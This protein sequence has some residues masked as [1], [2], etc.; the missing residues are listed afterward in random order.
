MPVHPFLNAFTTGEITDQLIART[1]WDKYQNAAA[2]LK[3]FVV[4]PYG[5][6]AR[7]AGTF[8]AGLAKDPS[9]RVR[10]RKFE[11]SITQAY[12]VEFG[13]LYARFWANRAP[14]LEAG[15]PVEVVTP[16]TVD[17]LRELRFEQ[18]ADVLY[19]THRN[20]PPAKLQRT[21][22][23]SFQLD[24][25][26][27][28]P[29]PTFEQE[30]FPA[31]T[32]TLS[33]TSGHIVT[34]TAS[35]SVFL[36]GDVGR[37]IR[38][39]VGRGIITA[40]GG[41]TTVTLDIL[42]AFDS[43]G[44]IAAGDWRMDGS[45]NAGTLTTTG[46]TPVNASV[47]LTSSLAAFRIPADENAYVY[48]NNGIVRITE[49]V[50]DT[51]VHGVI[52]KA[53]ADPTDL[54]ADAGAWTL[55]RQAWSVQNGFP[56]VVALFAQRLWFAGSNNFPDRVWGSVVADYENFG[57]GVADDDAVEY[58]LAMSGV[59]LI[60]W[61]KALPDGLGIGTMAGEVTLA[62]GGNDAPLTPTNATAKER[63]FYG[64]DYTVDAMRTSNL[65]LFLQRG[66]R[67]IRELTTNPES[68]NSEYVAP[69]LT[70]LAEQL[71]R[72][73]LVEMDR[74][75]SPDS[76]LFAVTAAGVLLTCAYERP[77]NVI[78]WS[79]HETQ[80]DFESVA[81]I[82]NNCGSGD[83]VWVAVNRATQS[84]A[85]WAAGFWA[86]GYWHPNYWALAGFVN[87][88]GIEF[89]DGVMNTDAGLRYAG[90]PAGTFTGLGHL[91]G[92]TVKAI[93]ANGTVYDLLVAGGSVSL[94]GGVTTDAIEIGLHFTSTLQTLRPELQG[95]QGTAQARR[96]HWAHVTPR[97]YCTV[98]RL[99]I[100]TESALTPQEPRILEYPEGID[101]SVPYTG[102]LAR[103][104]NFG[105]NREGQITI[106]TTEPKPCTILA[107]TGGLEM[108]DA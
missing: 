5:G 8:F 62:G 37:Q 85:W 93:A 60:R 100:H 21:S 69:D 72:E 57:R 58:Q 74:A 87:K 15:I 46:T 71:T 11:F 6:A 96:K 34:A 45:P 25:I 36:A 82:P 63:T 103:H 39:G 61:L 55:E 70:I 33:A 68:I 20:H 43:T 77:E 54:V 12:I 24:P 10:L 42:D 101:T 27:F 67:R 9:S 98:G 32:L 48:M 16:Y 47:V 99:I 91:E 14:V 38:S 44:P 41:G 78:G 2:C 53:M 64:A 90:V 105:W 95:P 29:T 26:N 52:V 17:E 66:A 84:G 40:V 102:D 23:T 1:T 94:P 31:A 79:H 49:F 50:S 104:V 107:L 3:N 19:I 97:V 13:H 88:R 92:L 56:G 73:S 108:D 75:I 106:Q 83:E 22:A 65:V 86:T 35:A 7:R 81:V 4:R 30:I 18:S 59:N 89:F 76:I 51:V 80:G 28:N